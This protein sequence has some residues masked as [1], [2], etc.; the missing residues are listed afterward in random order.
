MR[1][2]TIPNIV[3]NDSNDLHTVNQKIPG[4]KAAQV[5]STIAAMIMDRSIDLNGNVFES[6][7][8]RGKPAI[9]TKR[10]TRFI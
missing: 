2:A 3:Q 9:S 5:F 1:A 8:A 10:G 4:E 7:S 6:S